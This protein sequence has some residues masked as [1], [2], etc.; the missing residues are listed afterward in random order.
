MTWLQENDKLKNVKSLRPHI[1]CRN[2]GLRPRGDADGGFPVTPP[3]PRSTVKA[4]SR[5]AKVTSG[6]SE[7][8]STNSSDQSLART[9]AGT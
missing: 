8:M 3:P 9:L 2:L 6:S 4:I 5:C 7:K 1:E